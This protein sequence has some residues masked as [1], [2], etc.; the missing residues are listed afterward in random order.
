MIDLILMDVL[1]ND[2]EI[3]V[4]VVVDSFV[5]VKGGIDRFLVL[6]Y[7]FVFGVEYV[8]NFSFKFYFEVWFI[9][10]YLVFELVGDE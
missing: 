4:E 9:D 7:Y 5:N 10:N 3:Y 1:F 2:I 6:L 8:F